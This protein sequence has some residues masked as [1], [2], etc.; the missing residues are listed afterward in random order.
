M[1]HRF[2][3]FHKRTWERCFLIVIVSGGSREWQIPQVKLPNATK[4]CYT[5]SN[6]KL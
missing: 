2:Q 3:L 4:L 5:Y 6:D 1:K